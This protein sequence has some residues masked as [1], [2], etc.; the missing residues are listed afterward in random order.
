MFFSNAHISS[1]R[2]KTADENSPNNPDVDV[3]R[4]KYLT[5]KQNTIVDSSR[6]DKDWGWRHVESAVKIQVQIYQY[7]NGLYH[8]H[9]PPFTKLLGES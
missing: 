6:E 9:S 5:W 8:V 2:P 4:S 3:E 1:S 7:I